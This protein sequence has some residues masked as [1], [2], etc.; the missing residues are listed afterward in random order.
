MIYILVRAVFQCGDNSTGE[1]T[2]RKH[3]RPEKYLLPYKININRRYVYK[4]REI[5]NEHIKPYISNHKREERVFCQYRVYV[6]GYDVKHMKEKRG[7]NY[8]SEI[9]H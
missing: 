5:T 9:Y 4:G 7:D 1:L 8:E 6:Q 3:S 2:E